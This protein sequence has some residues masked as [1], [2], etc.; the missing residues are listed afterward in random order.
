MNGNGFC[1]YMKV[2]GSVPT[3]M[4]FGEEKQDEMMTCGVAILIVCGLTAAERPCQD[5]SLSS[6]MDQ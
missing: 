6:Y 2:A 5:I 4:R 1:G 3:F